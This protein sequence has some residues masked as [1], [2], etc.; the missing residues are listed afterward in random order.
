VANHSHCISFPIS[1]IVELKSHDFWLKLPPTIAM[2]REFPGSKFFQNLKGSRFSLVARKATVSYDKKEVSSG[3]KHHAMYTI[4]E[5]Y[6]RFTGAVFPSHWV[7]LVLWFCK[8]I[9]VPIFDFCISPGKHRELNF[10]LFPK[11]AT[12]I[13]T[14]EAQKWVSGLERP[15]IGCISG[16]L[17]G[18]SKKRK[19]GLNL[20]CGTAKSMT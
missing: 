16:T 11:P 5:S 7:Y 4:G 10:P 15:S 6:S 9:G 18:L 12:E 20:A 13:E 19:W 17:S 3:N 2:T 1:D 8:L 14:Y